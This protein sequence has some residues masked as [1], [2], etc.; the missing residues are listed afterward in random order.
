MLAMD[1]YDVRINSSGDEILSQRVY[2][3]TTLSFVYFS[4]HPSIT[5]TASVAIVD[6]K[7]QRSES[8][9]FMMT[10]GKYMHIQCSIHM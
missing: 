3:K 9:I 6:T 8:T 2:N 7:G 1:F 4:T 10:I 5:F